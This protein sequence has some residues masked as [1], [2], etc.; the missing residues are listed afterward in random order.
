M[1]VGGDLEA[2]E[3]LMRGPRVLNADGKAI[4]MSS[5]TR[6]Y[7]GMNQNG[8]HGGASPQEVVVPLAILAPR[9]SMPK[10]WQE[11]GFRPADFW[12][13]ESDQPVVPVQAEK[14]VKPIK[15]T[16]P[17]DHLPFELEEKTEVV[18]VVADWVKRLV[19][20][21]LYL[22][23][24]KR[25][26]RMAP[27]ADRVGAALEALSAR[28][29]KMTAPALARVLNMPLPKLAGF[30]AALQKLLNLD[31]VF[32]V[33]FDANSNSWELDEGM[34]QRQFLD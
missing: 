21:E 5:V 34:A 4:L 30:G 31:G 11:I 3:V 10:G 29:G 32:V 1:D 17:K 24:E 7:A 8:Y 12:L 16:V 2:G 19:A 28:G 26:K 6:R 13:I 23:Q 14:V 18:S 22:A 20:S 33:T 9:S 27:Q 25:W 15:T